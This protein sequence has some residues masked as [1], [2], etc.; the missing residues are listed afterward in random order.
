MVL[1]NGEIKEMD[2]PANLLSNKESTF[3]SMASQANLV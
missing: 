1:E 2:T 3:Y